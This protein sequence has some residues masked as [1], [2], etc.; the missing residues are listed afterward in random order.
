MVGQVES[1]R[2]LGEDLVGRRGR[3]RLG[4]RLALQKKQTD[5]VSTSR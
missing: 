2:V 3:H 1:S 5:E 4:L